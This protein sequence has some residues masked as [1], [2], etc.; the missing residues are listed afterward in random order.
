M[1]VHFR[2]WIES[3]FHLTHYW[4]LFYDDA[5]FS[6]HSLYLSLAPFSFRI[7]VCFTLCSLGTSKLFDIL[8]VCVY[9]PRCWISFL[10]EMSVCVSICYFLSP[11]RLLLFYSIVCL[12]VIR[13]IFFLKY[14]LYSGPSSSTFDNHVGSWVWKSLVSTQLFNN[15]TISKSIQDTN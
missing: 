3:R 6:I 7:I 11:L 5:I 14:F 2:S 12:L 13:R 8:W 4:M 10:V 15:L 1:P 9:F